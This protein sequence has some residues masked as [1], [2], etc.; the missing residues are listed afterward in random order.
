[1]CFLDASKSFDHVSHTVLDRDGP[2][3]VVRILVFL[4]ENQ[5]MCVRC[6]SHASDSINASNGVRQEA[7]D[8]TTQKRV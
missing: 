2:G 4:Y 5:Q 7:Y 1:M 6:G 8:S 3:Y